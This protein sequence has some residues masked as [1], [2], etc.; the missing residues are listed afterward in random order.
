M[1]MIPRGDRQVPKEGAVPTGSLAAELVPPDLCLQQQAPGGSCPG[2]IRGS[3]DLL[4]EHMPE[5]P[6][7]RERD[8]RFRDEALPLLDD[9]T[10]YALS[11]TRAEGER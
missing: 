11:L 9:V 5:P 8:A 10:R 6:T 4:S 3:R 7:T 1:F 2:I